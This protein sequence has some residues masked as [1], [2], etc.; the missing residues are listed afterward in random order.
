LDR[1]RERFGLTVSTR[2]TEV[3]VQLSR[4]YGHTL[5]KPPS[6][7]DL[8]GGLARISTALADELP[9]EERQEGIIALIG[10]RL[11]LDPILAE[12]GSVS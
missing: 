2:I 4:L 6:P 9:S 8:S 12:S 7:A 11:D 10:L 5:N 1:C 3:L